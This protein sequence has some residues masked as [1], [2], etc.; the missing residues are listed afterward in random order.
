MK[1]IG[2]IVLFF[3]SMC[4]M[5]MANRSSYGGNDVI[6]DISTCL[7]NA[8]TKEL[9]KYFSSTVSMAL[10]NDEGVYSKVQAEIILREFFNRNQPTDISIIQRL[11]SNPNF[12][13]IV[14]QMATSRRNYRIS[15][16]LV[17]ESNSFKINE[18]RID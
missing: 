16:K 17:S 6:D 9:S 15:Y 5:S 12:R 10:I 3:C 2:F 8:N 1:K 7:R 14:I 18:L 4:S 13:F 11:D